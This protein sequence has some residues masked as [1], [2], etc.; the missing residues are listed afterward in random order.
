MTTPLTAREYAYLL[1]VGPGKHER[2][3]EILGI[4]PSDACNADE[5][6]WK[7]GRPCK[8][9]FWKWKSGLDDTRPMQEHIEAILRWFHLKGD[10]VRELWVDYDLILECVGHYPASTGPGIYF[11]REIIRQ[12]AQLGLAIDCD[13]YFVEDPH[14]A[15][16]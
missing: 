16:N 4:Q 10:A 7:T 11:N 8:R 5:T 15:E 2:I 12:V 14:R 13:F 9:M 3:T 6:N 1:I